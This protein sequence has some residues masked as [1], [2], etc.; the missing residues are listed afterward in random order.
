MANNE[1]GRR[2]ST[3]KMAEGINA[4]VAE[5]EKLQRR[6]HGEARGD[7]RRGCRR[8]RRARRVDRHQVT[9]APSG[10]A[11]EVSVSGFL[12]PRKLSRPA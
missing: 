9:G 1:R 3:T 10:Q 4:F 6:D 12:K 8:A 7:R 5:T 2:G 11:A